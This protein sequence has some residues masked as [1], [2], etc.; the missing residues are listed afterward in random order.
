MT[1]EDAARSHQESIESA[2][3]VQAVSKNTTQTFDRLR[4]VHTYG[5]LL[6]DLYSCVEQLQPFVLEQAL[7]DRFVTFY[8]GVIPFQG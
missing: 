2:D 7:R 5:V 4:E 6:Y 3:L 8:E 1:P